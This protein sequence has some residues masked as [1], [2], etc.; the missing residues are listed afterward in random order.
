MQTSLYVATLK[1]NFS[2]YVICQTLITAA[3]IAV[4]TF[5]PSLQE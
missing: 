4:H 3:Y 5:T 1:M 2:T